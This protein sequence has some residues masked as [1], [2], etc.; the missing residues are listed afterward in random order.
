MKRIGWGK[1]DGGNDW[2]GCR[3]VEYE[4]ELEGGSR[5]GCSRIHAKNCVTG[6]TL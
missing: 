2:R 5:V 3:V 4:E 1:A 6:T